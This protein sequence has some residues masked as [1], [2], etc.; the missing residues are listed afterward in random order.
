MIPLQLIRFVSWIRGSNQNMWVNNSPFIYS[1]EDDQLQYILV[2]RICLRPFHDHGSY[3]TVAVA[4]CS[5]SL[6]ISA[7]KPGRH[8]EDRLIWQKKI[9]CLTLRFHKTVKIVQRP[10]SSKGVKGEGELCLGIRRLS[11]RLSHP[12][13]N[14]SIRRYAA[15]KFGVKSAEYSIGSIAHPRPSGLNSRPTGRAITWVWLTIETCGMFALNSESHTV[16]LTGRNFGC[17]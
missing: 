8:N 9:S 14:V 17:T 2:C 4:P 13:H 5:M 16:Q 7:S 3:R 10:L 6:N 1:W 11:I 15:Q 12:C